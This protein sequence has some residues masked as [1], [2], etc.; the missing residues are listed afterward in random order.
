[1]QLVGKLTQD[2]IAGLKDYITG[3]N[4]DGQGES[5]E[6]HEIRVTDGELYVSFWH[7]G[8]NYAIYTQEELSALLGREQSSAPEQRKPECPIIGADGNI[9][10]I[11]GIAAR[12]LKSNGMADTAKEMSS[13]VMASDSYNSALDIM[14]EYVEPVEAGGQG[15]FSMVMRM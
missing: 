7:T 15:Q 14:M 6:Q 4:A 12:T 10:N 1:M 2:D 3:Q 13:R 5:L 8:N 11:M 9:F